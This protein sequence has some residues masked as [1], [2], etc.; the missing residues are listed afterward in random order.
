M[1]KLL[2]IIFLVL[3][4]LIPVLAQ[5]DAV[6]LNRESWEET[7]KE[8]SY[9]ELEG[10]EK[11]KKKNEKEKTKDY[12]P[13]KPWINWNSGTV[14]AILFGLIILALLLILYKIFGNIAFGG[15]I[16]RAEQRNF[17]IEDIE[18]NLEQADLKYH[19][20]T[21]LTSGDYRKAIRV[22]YLSII[23]EFSQRNW[24]YWKKD[25]TNYSYVHEMRGRNE[26]SAFRDLTL[27]F[28]IVWYGDAEIKE[29]H[30]TKLKPHFQSFI[31]QL[32]IPMDEN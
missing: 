17:T 29:E 9:E 27:A 32:N 3:G 13:S 5:D 28:E 12:K 1:L 26:H 30:F 31:H 7:I 15:K 14:K 16:K 11:K 21:S 25:K 4:N 8:I 24:I 22:Y 6:Q 2:V 18:E 20:E 23:K 19:L 10:E